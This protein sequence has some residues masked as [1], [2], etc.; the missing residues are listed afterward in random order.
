MVRL[1]VTTLERGTVDILPAWTTS[2]L[3]ILTWHGCLINKNQQRT[4][5]LPGSENFDA[6]WQWRGTREISTLLSELSTLTP[7]WLE[8]EYREIHRAPRRRILLQPHFAAQVSPI[9]RAL[10]PS[11]YSQVSLRLWK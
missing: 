4:N 9:E 7:L 1:M 3:H 6:R 10:E 2:G 11:S 8:F 5:V